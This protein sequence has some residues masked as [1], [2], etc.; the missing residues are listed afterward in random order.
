MKVASNWGMQALRGAQ[1]V[2][3]SSGDTSPLLTG[4]VSFQAKLA[5]CDFCVT[6]S[7]FLN[8]NH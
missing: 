6:I 7:Q 5:V 3:F 8:T 4:L 1:L 2:G